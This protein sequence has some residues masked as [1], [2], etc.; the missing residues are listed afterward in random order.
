MAVDGVFGYEQARSD[1]LVAQAI[2]D[3]VCDLGFTFAE[4]GRPRIACCHGG[5]LIGFAERES[6]CRASA[7]TSSGFK[8]DLER[9]CAERGSRRLPGL[10][11]WRSKVWQDARANARL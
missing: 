9:G 10:G 3:Q 4:R 8:L 11:H 2:G 7:Q 5:N 1:L 6:D